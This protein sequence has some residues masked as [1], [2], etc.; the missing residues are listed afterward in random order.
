MEILSYIPLFILH[1]LTV[2]LIPNAFI[3][4]QVKEN[5]CPILKI[6]ARDVR[7]VSIVIHAEV[8]RGSFLCHKG[9]QFNLPELRFF[10]RS[11]IIFRVDNF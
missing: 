6:A 9:H 5:E 7:N 4:L 8:D 3:R 11:P 1:R 2:R 10:L